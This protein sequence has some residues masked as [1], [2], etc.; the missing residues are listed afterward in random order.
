MRTL[1]WGLKNGLEYRQNQCNDDM[2]EYGAIEY[3]H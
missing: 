3:Q 2:M 1:T